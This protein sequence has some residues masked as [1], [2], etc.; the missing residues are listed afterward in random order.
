M[1][2]I[3]TLYGEGYINLDVAQGI[4]MKDFTQFTP[5]VEDMLNKFVIFAQ[6]GNEE[7]PLKMF[8]TQCE[9]IDFMNELVK[10]ERNNTTSR[11]RKQVSSA[12]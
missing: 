1:K 11:K 7:V 12:E 2:W 9:A 6:Y 3:K 4:H 5:R 10:D 8:M